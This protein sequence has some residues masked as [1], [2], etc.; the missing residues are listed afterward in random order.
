[1]FS[2][3]HDSA[4]EPFLLF[5]SWVILETTSC[6]SSW[7]KIVNFTH[8]L[9]IEVIFL[10]QNGRE[11]NLGLVMTTFFFP[12]EEK[13]G[14]QCSGPEVLQFH[15]SHFNFLWKIFYAK[16]FNFFPKFYAM[17]KHFST[18]QQIVVAQKHIFAWFLNIHVFLHL[19]KWFILRQLLKFALF[20]EYAVLPPNQIALIKYL[21]LWVAFGSEKR[22]H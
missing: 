13:K 7:I 16:N 12:W 11:K 21:F 15:A 4:A 20:S 17:K 10:V 1:M 18:S 19:W 14:F 3:L 9:R 22:K 5:W 2:R 6:A 8:S